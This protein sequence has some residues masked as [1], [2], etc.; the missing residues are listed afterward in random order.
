M[1]DFVKYPKLNEPIQ[2]KRLRWRNKRF[3]LFVC[4]WYL[5][6][7]KIGTFSF[8][9]SMKPD[10]Y[11][12]AVTRVYGASTAPNSDDVLVCVDLTNAD[13][14]KVQEQVEIRLP[15]SKYLSGENA[16]L[17]NWTNSVA[18]SSTSTFAV[19]INPEGSTCAA[20]LGTIKIIEEGSLQPGLN[21]L[22]WSQY[23]KELENINNIVVI[24][25]TSADRFRTAI[26]DGRTFGYLSQK[27]DRQIYEMEYVGSTENGD[28]IK[29]KV[30]RRE[31]DLEFYFPLRQSGIHWE[32][33]GRIIWV[34]YDIVGG[35]LAWL[36]IFTPIL[37]G[38]S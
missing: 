12:L 16:E 2:I 23:S 22:T 31:R 24:D 10:S 27:I 37:T 15:V 14:L 35:P 5:L 38:R 33:I 13:D 18:D 11:T 1:N 17:Q 9:Y 8:W 30:L 7:P 36:G 21:A 3:L 26:T 20:N 32:N 34:L 28:A 4:I 19:P 29:K 25:V 6:G